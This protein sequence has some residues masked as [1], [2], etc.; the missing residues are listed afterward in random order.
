MIVEMVSM[1][2]KPAGRVVE[3]PGSRKRSGAKTGAYHTMFANNGSGKL[4]FSAI[5][6]MLRGTC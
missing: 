1:D 2:P 4:D 5:I 6:K 3:N